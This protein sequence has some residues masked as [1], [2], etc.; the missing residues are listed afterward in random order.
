[1][2]AYRTNKRLTQGA[3]IADCRV[4]T[5]MAFRSWLVA[6]KREKPVNASH[7]RSKKHLLP[8]HV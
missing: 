6:E 1:L 8:P 7:T 3:K 2:H 4:L 5:W